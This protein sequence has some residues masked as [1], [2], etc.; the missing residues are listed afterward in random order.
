M[1]LT[2]FIDGA[3]RGN[4]GRSA[5]GVALYDPEGQPLKE[6]GFEIGITTNN[7][8]E[9]TALLYGLTETLLYVHKLPDKINELELTIYSDSELLI[10]QMTGRYQ[11][12]N[13]DIKRLYLLAQ[14]LV[15]GLGKISFEKLSHDENKTADQLANKALDKK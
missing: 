9:Y 6:V 13:E 1:K 2:V 15:S 7:I 12:K 5:I 14:R 8:A 10:N 4:P 3:S 11:V